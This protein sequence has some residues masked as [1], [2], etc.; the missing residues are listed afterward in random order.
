MTK[1]LLLH[2]CCAPCTIHPL[3][4]LRDEGW[5]VEGWFYNPNIHPYREWQHRR[6]T[7]AE[8]AGLVDLPVTW[9]EGYD[10]N[11]FLQEALA[12]GPERCLSCYRRRLSAAAKAAREG[13]YDAFSTTLLVSP[14]QKHDAIRRLGEE[15]AAQQDVPFVYRDFRPGFRAAQAKARELGLY[16]QPYCGC[17]FSERERYQK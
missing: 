5:E 15:L 9:V 2:N 7:L 4:V 12:A 6:D 11:E 1:R 10:L 14:Y 17:I 3:A 16:R 8:Y 13:G